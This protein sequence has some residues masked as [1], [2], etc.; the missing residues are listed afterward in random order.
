M[1][2]EIE[3]KEI[4]WLQLHWDSCKV[5]FDINSNIVLNVQV[6]G[7]QEYFEIKS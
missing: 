7:G 2:I 6:Q 4:S 3:W 1:P 5:L